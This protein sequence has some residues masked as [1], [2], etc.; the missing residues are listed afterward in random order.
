MKHYSLLL[1]ILVVAV[2]VQA[3]ETF[4]VASIKPYDKAASGQVMDV[5]IEG[6][7]S[8]AAP[9]VLPASDF[10]VE[11]AQDGVSQTAKVRITKFTLIQQRNADNSNRNAVDLNGMKMLPYHSVSFV[12]PKGLHPGPAEVVVSYKGQRGNAV[13]LEI[14]EKPL[15]PVVGTMAVMS[16]GPMAPNRT[17]PMKPE[18]NDLGWRL[19]RGATTRLSVHPLVDPDDPNSAVLIRFK[20]GANVYD[21]VTRISSTPSG[22]ESS[23]RAV[24]FRAA[25][26]ELEVEVPAA[27]TIGKVEV[28]IRVKANGQLSDSVMM[29]ATIT[30]MTRAAESPNVS[31]P[32]VLAI[33]PKRVGAGQSLMVSI[34]RR[35]TLEPSPKETRV[36]IE[37]NNARYFAT[38]ERNSALVG[39]SREPDAPVVL[40]VRTTRELIG[41]VQLRVLNSLR[42]EQT[43]LSEPVSMEIVDEVLPSELISVSEATDADLARLREI[44]EAQKE[45]GKQFSPYDPSRRYLAVRALNIDY[46]AKFVRVT[47]EQ[48]SQKFTL[49]P[50]DFSLYSGDALILRLPKELTGGDITFTIE[51]SSGDRYSTPVSKTFTLQPR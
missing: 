35:R 46:N 34:D 29:T 15:R 41:R 3:Q 27:L 6:L 14:V 19:E 22:V 26:E 30:D 13:A 24:G 39:P 43:G 28:E 45:A 25:R 48:G 42:D 16:V 4:T 51:N 33:T 12:V 20:Q 23:G 38:I 9:T 47:L 40:F 5:L 17:Q 32:R 50:A 37:Q 44:Y 31:A 11:V 18:G 21:A 2:S 1:L 7:T 49:T 36:I 8:G 10:K